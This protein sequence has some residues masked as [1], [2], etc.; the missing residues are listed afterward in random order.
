MEKFDHRVIRLEVEVSKEKNPRQ[1][2]QCDRIELTCRSKGPVIRAEAAAEDK[3]AAF[4]LALDKL[5][6]QLRKAAD[7]WNQSTTIEEENS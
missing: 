7:R 4:D 3:S 6:A 1:A 2:D 5:M